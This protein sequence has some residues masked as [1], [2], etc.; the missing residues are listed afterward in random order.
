MSDPSLQKRI[1]KNYDVGFIMEP[2]YD[3]YQSSDGLLFGSDEQH[4]RKVVHALEIIDKKYEPDRKSY[5][6]KSI[7]RE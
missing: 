6:I 2:L 7:N 1:A 4:R 5:G 3:Y